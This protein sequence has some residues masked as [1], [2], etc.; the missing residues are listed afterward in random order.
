MKK[1]LSMLLLIV[2]ISLTVSLSGCS[3]PHSFD[4]KDSTASCLEAGVR[5]RECSWCGVIEEIPVEALGHD[6]FLGKCWRCKEILEGWKLYNEVDEFEVPTGVVYME[7]Y[8]SFEGTYS[9]RY[10]TKEAMTA[11]MV[12]RKKGDKGLT[13]AFILY[14]KYSNKVKAELYGDTYKILYQDEEGNRYS[15]T[16]FME[17]DDTNLF[18]Q[19]GPI[20]DLL[21]NNEKIEVYLET[22]RYLTGNANYLFTIYTSNFNEIFK[23][24]VN[25]N[26]ED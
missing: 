7:S 2:T 24:F 1:I 14:D 22:T 11:K 16:G 26:F 20:F 25:T 3:C 15:G 17:Y 5:R 21:E 8:V 23:E 18:L 12:L 9:D 6:I 19:G 13:I 4:Y 10:S